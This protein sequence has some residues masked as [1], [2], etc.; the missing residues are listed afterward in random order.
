MKNLQDKLTRPLFVM[1]LKGC[2]VSITMLIAA[3]AAT[4]QSVTR[5]S[6]VESALARGARLAVAAADTAAARAQLTGARLLEDPALGAAYSKSPPELHFTIDWP[7]PFPGVRGARISSAQAGL[8]AA[9]YR[10]RFE[11]AL[12]TLD[13]DTIY[14]RALATAEHARISSRNAA[15]ADTLV[16]IAVARR[17]AG[18]ASDLEVELARVNAGQEHNLAIADSLELTSVL[19]D[20][21]TVTALAQPITLADSLTLPDT[22]AVDVAIGNPLQI[23]ASMQSL[24]AAQLG[25][26]AERRSVFGS[27]SLMAGVETHDKDQPGMLPTFGISIPIPLLNRNK[28]GVATANAELLRARAELNATTI[29]YNATVAR[30]RRERTVAYRRAIMDKELLESANRVAT[31]SVRG[32]REGAF[33]IANVLEAQK[34]ARDVLRQYVDDLADAW[35]ADATLRALTLTA[36]Q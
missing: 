29:E 5:A 18:D 21:A 4:G 36:G 30:L 14:T 20:L 33:P 25:L 34:S 23:A 2:I 6:A 15:V 10:Y 3:S 11:R 27:P 9:E 1:L 32:Y 8:R 17:D 22:T 13:V 12:A 35:I 16:R 19:S 26:R 24:N 7:I 28:A 31:M